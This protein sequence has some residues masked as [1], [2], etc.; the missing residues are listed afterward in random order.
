MLRKQHLQGLVMLGM[1][2]VEQQPEQE[3]QNLPHQWCLG[4]RQALCAQQQQLLAHTQNKLLQQSL[5]SARC[6]ALP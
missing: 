1:V 2:M 3:L 6:W 4:H 5:V